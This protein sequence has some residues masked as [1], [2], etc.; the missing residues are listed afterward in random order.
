MRC[1]VVISGLGSH[2]KAVLRIVSISASCLLVSIAWFGLGGVNV[3][4]V[5]VHWCLCCSGVNVLL[6]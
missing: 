4:V 2:V 1:I 3:V 5:V 6:L